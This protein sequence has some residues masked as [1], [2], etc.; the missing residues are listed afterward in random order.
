MGE[1][2]ERRERMREEGETNMMERNS[3][4]KRVEERKRVPEEKL[5][6]HILLILFLNTHV[7]TYFRYGEDPTLT[8]TLGAAYVTGMQ[9]NKPI[10]HIKHHKHHKHN[11]H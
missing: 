4:R 11:Y 9:V 10:K 2:R 1:N 6:I 3:G 7:I 8:G 5:I